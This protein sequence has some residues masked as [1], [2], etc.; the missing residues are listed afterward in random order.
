[1][2]KLTYFL[3]LQ[4]S[5][6]TPSAIFVNQT[7]YIRDLLHK[8]GMTTSKPCPTPCKPHTQVLSTSG[9]PLKDPTL[10]RSI[11]GALQYLTFTKPDIAYSVNTVFQYMTNPTE[12]HFHMV[13]RILRY[14]QGTLTYG[15]HFGPGPWH[16]SAYSD[17][18]W[19]TD[20]STKRSTTGC[21]VFLGANPISWQSKRYVHLSNT[22]QGSGGGMEKSSLFSG[23]G[24][25]GVLVVK[26]IVHDKCVN[27]AYCSCKWCGLQ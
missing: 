21:V 6:P 16:L 10:Y 12:V 24:K 26:G 2:G 5:Y 19:A 7:K 23:I 1:M 17:S 27:Q 14:I 13:Q 9:E 25:G 15:I 3:G 20:P 22:S 8:A 11:V 18:D 4:V